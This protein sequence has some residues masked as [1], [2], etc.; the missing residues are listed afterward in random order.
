MLSFLSVL[1]FSFSACAAP[2]STGTYSVELVQDKEGD[3]VSQSCLES[4]ALDQKAR[5][6]LKENSLSAEDL[7][8]GK[9]PGSVLCQKLAAKVIYL[10]Q[11]KI[12]DAF[13]E[14]DKEVISLARFVR[15]VLAREH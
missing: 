10:E 15:F 8:G 6:Y 9:S 2:W 12:S 13:C 11:E 5:A 4:C 7:E 1:I 3:W 14:Q